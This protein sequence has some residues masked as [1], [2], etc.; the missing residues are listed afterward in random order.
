MYNLQPILLVEDSPDDSLIIKQGL[1]QERVSNHVVTVS[2]GE[3]ARDYLLGQGKYAD[4]GEYPLPCL[5]L[6]DL[7]IR[8][9]P[10]LELLGWIRSQSE[11]RKLPV[12][13]LTRSSAPEDVRAAYEQGANSYL[14]KPLDLEALQGVLKSINGYWMLTVQ[15]PAMG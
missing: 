7:K 9:M 13:V 1:T 6:L 14:V 3:E 8:G 10:G 12:V 4:R 15:K 2:S 11:L 5:L